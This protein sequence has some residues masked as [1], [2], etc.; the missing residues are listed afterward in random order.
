MRAVLPVAGQRA[1][2]RVAARRAGVAMR[3]QR[4]QRHHRARQQAVGNGDVHIAPLPRALRVHQRRQNTHH[5]RQRAAQ[6][7]RHRHVGQRGL[8]RP[9]SHLIGHAR[10][11][12]IIQVMARR[13]AQRA[14]LAVAGDAANHQARVVPRQG[15]VVGLQA[16][17]HAGAK[18]L[19]QH[20]GLPSQRRQH[21]LPVGVFQVQPQAPLVAVAHGA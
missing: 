1:R 3:V 6:N 15:R 4:G 11:G 17:G 9:A 2:Q 20:V 7:V 19:D 13:I 12:R 14:V 21:G 5:R 10:V 18:A 8:M 16:R